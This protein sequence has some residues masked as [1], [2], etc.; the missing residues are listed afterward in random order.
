MFCEQIFSSTTETLLTVGSLHGAGEERA[1]R[2]PFSVSSALP[3]A[4]SWGGLAPC[5]G[6]HLVWYH[7]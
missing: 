6:R 3:G 4:R 5:L 2:V 1:G 7:V